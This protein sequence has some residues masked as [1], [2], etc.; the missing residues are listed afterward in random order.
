VSTNDGRSVSYTYGTWAGTGEHVMTGVTYPDTT[1][2]AYTW[3]GANSLTSGAPLLASAVDPAYTGTGARTRYVYNYNATYGGSNIVNGT[4]LEERN[5]D[6]GE[7]SVSLPLGGGFYPKVMTGGVDEVTRKF[8]GNNVIESVDEEGRK[9]VFT[10]QTVGGQLNAGFLLTVTNDAGAVTTYTRDAVG[11]ELTRTDALGGVRTTTYSAT[12]FV[13]TERDELNRLTTHTRDA[14]NR[15]T[16]TDFPG[17][18]FESYTYTGTGLLKTRRF[19][20]GAT[21]TYNYDG[22]GNLT[23]HVNA[24]GQTTVHTYHNTG[25]R[26]STTDPLGHVTSFLYDWR[27]RLLR[28]TH[29]DS[30]FVESTYGIHDR[31]LSQRNEL[32]QVTTHMYDAFNRRLTTTDPLNRTTSW[33]YGFAGACCG[34]SGSGGPLSVTFPGGRTIVYTYDRSGK[35]ISQTLAHGTPLAA[36]VGFVYNSVGDLVSTVDPMGRVTTRG[37]DLLHRR[38][39]EVT[40]F[41]A[42]TFGYDAVGN[43]VTRTGS[44]GAVTTTTYN[45]QDQRLTVRN[46]LGQ[47]SSSAYDPAGRLTLETSAGGRK[48]RRTYDALDRV[49][50]MVSGADTAAA[51]ATTYGYDA[52]GNLTRVTDP[53]NRVTSHAYNS[54]HFRT[55]TTNA[56]NQVTMFAYDAVGR[57]T[58]TTF[59]D[60]R[61]EGRSYDAAGQL[62]SVTDPLNETTSYGYDGERRMTSLTTPRGHTRQWSYDAAGRLFRRTHPD[63]TYEQ[64]TYFADHQLALHRV[65]SGVTATYTYTTA[66]RLAGRDW[67][68]AT[69]DVSF[70]W[71][72]LGRLV[73]AVNAESSV[74]WTYDVLSRKVTETQLIT[75]FGGP[76]RTVSYGYDPDGF[77]A[78]VTYPDGHVVEYSHTARGQMQAVTAGGPPPLAQYS[79]N[80]GGERTGLTLENGLTTNSTFNA[81][82]RLLS[83]SHTVGGSAHDSVSY[84]LDSMGRRT[85]MVRP[86]MNSLFGYDAAG[87][88]TSAS[89]FN[90]PGPASESFAYDGMGNRMSSTGVVDASYTAN[91][92]EQYSAVNGQGQSHDVNGNLLL[93]AQPNVP[94]LEFEWDS[95]N[96][97]RAQTRAGGAPAGRARIMNVY[98]ALHRRIAKQVFQGATSGSGVWNLVK[99]VTFVY[100]GWNVI[101]E[102]E[103]S[104]SGAVSA[105][106][107][108]TWGADV[109]GT[110][111]GA[112][113][114]G[115]LILAEE[116]DVGV[117]S[118]APVAHY[119][120]YDGNGNVIGVTD[121]TGWG[122]DVTY[123]YTAFGAMA[124]ANGS[125]S[126]WGN[127]N[128]WKF[129]TKYHDEE[130]EGLTG[131]YYYGYRHYLPGVGRWASR[132][133]IEERGGVNLYGMVGNRVVNQM[134]V[135]GLKPCCV[136]T[137]K[138]V[139]VDAIEVDESHAAEM[140]DGAMDAI[141]KRAARGRF[142]EG[143]SSLNYG[144][145]WEIEVQWEAIEDKT[146]EVKTKG[147][148]VKSA[149][150]EGDN[151]SVHLFRADAVN[152]G[153][154][155]RKSARDDALDE[156]RTNTGC[157]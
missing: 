5:F 45:A 47:T 59:P 49:I 109:S 36:T 24:L 100:E 147:T 128:P 119:Y 139:N 68:D 129:S 67:S 27:G 123:R 65:P 150:S 34:A 106:Y 55:S 32:G 31:L 114:V 29:P 143:A 41:G 82:G 87:Q 13:L 152:E 56:L 134:D 52:D 116:L 108:Y 155:H 16:R 58:L 21:E 30:T 101:E 2:A 115:G 8:V 98:D 19:R 20:N 111:D 151:F 122:L 85:G 141:A 71:D 81:A 75:G 54:R 57:L 140:A 156:C 15:V 144:Y 37:Y 1:A 48:V 131:T 145:T 51:A 148:F 124:E 121:S 40:P 99:T 77:V 96:R 126:S 112:G 136:C 46:G 69:A 72:A 39:M 63:G 104:P 3:C 12:N 26:A 38:V 97:M 130:V 76:G 118:N 18:S 89:H 149:G 127:R 14:S 120:Y 60:T 88:L 137:V 93:L 79:Y 64:F 157:R 50:T 113:G 110:R 117:P 80:V 92:L 11:N 133:P 28:T 153:D 90:T 42:T 138:S 17:G 23:S 103:L 78:T 107:R 4:V 33:T 125:G 102:R 25:L 35:R 154:G 84:T 146:F 70:S 73:G 95:E 10:Y 132:D 83:H 135:L 105:A 61:T 44:T 22:L 53:L 43:E 66:G 91:S 86:G 9:N 7:V 94:S 74:S 62:V 142:G 6:T